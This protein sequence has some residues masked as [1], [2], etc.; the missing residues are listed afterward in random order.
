MHTL[1]GDG[2]HDD[3][4]AIQE[5]L[6]GGMCEVTLPAPKVCYLISKTLEI[7][8][9]TRLVLPRYAEIKLADGANCPMIAN[10]TVLTPDYDGQG[11]RFKELCQS[12]LV[13]NV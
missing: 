2:I 11:G 8:S 5:M 3:Y 1:W 10:K 6:D 4:P 12:S 7:P 13:A 9:Y